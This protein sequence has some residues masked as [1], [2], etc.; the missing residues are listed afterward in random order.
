MLLRIDLWFELVA[1]VF[2]VNECQFNDFQSVF[3]A[4]FA[5]LCS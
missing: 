1:F 3:S 4:I 2:L 5:C